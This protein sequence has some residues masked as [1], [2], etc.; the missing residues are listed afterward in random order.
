MEITQGRAQQQVGIDIEPVGTWGR[1]VWGRRAVV[2]LGLAL[3]VTTQIG[4]MAA[5]ETQTAGASKLLA[6]AAVPAPQAPTAAPMPPDPATA[7]KPVVFGS[8]M[9]SGRFGNQPFSGY[10][11]DYVVSV[12]DRISVRM[13]GAFSFESVQAV[14]AQ[15]NIFIPNVGPVQLS[16]VRNAELTVQLESQVKRTFRSNVGVYASLESAQPVRIYV[17][18]SVR[19]P[20]LY[21][22]L[23]SDSV[24][25]YLDKAGGIDPDRGSYLAVEVMRSG[26]V[27]ARFNLYRFLLQGRID[28]LQLQDGDTVVVLP[29]QHTV[30]VQGEVLNPYLFEFDRGRIAAT[31]LLSMARPRPEATH[32]SIVRKLGAERRSEYHT[33][34]ALANVVI[35][36]GDEVNFTSD[37]YIGTI[38]VRVEGAHLG[39][40]TLVLPY[41]ARLKDALARIKPAPQ[42]NLPAIQLMRRSVAVR[43][44]ELLAAS[45]RSLETYALTARSATSEEAALRTREAELIMQF[46]E[47]TRNVQPRGQVL[48]SNRAEA[49]ETL[50]EDGDLLR[51]PEQS[52]TILVSGE[53]LMPNALVFDAR[54][55][56]DDYV[57]QAGGFTQGVDAARI[58]VLHQDGSVADSPTAVLRPGDEIMVLPKIQ[59]KRI[60]IARGITQILYQIAVAARVFLAL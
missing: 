33:L 59:T 29:R 54:A 48:L 40:R 32:M 39:E 19:A 50:L 51:V 13:W 17:T 41:G 7:T 22:G 10:N 15:G 49:P 56:V 60:E 4:A 18:G 35:E 24:L 34:G 2:A 55:S 16:G 3:S 47:R 45:V 52:N 14:D 44:K 43:Q 27:R 21:G 42:A 25:Y 11:A 12:G 58:L 9:F 26:Q 30:L 28:P 53:V 6:L 1:R 38:L 57:R 5:G 36:D 8:Q 37:K 31:E 23:S 20:G 46:I